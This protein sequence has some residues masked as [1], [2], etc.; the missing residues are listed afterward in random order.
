MI[1]RKGGFKWLS[2]FLQRFI[3]K[4]QKNKSESRKNENI[5]H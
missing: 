5:M 4:L 1:F 2:K 3:E